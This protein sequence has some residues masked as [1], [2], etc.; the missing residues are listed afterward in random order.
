MTLSNLP[1]ISTELSVK[2]QENADE[3]RFL[4]LTRKVQRSLEIIMNKLLEDVE[5]PVEFQKTDLR[6]FICPRSLA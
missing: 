5:T 3:A 1:F 6:V 4:M 2:S